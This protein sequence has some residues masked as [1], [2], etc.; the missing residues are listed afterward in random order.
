MIEEKA[1]EKPKSILQRH[2]P[3]RTKID[4]LHYHDHDKKEIEEMKIKETFANAAKK[5]P[6][7]K[8]MPKEDT[9]D[10]I[11]MVF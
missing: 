7:H 3:V 2:R 5:A 6:A 9:E 10:P 4:Y 8:E 1:V 11:P